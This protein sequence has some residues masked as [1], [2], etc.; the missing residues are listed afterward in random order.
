[1]ED[2][3]LYSQSELIEKTLSSA[4]LTNGVDERFIAGF[5]KKLNLRLPELLRGILLHSNG[6]EYNFGRMITPFIPSSIDELSTDE[7]W[8]KVFE[9]FEHQITDQTFERLK[10][11]ILPLGDDYSGE[12]LFFDLRKKNEYQIRI[13]S[14]DLNQEKGFAK[15]ESLGIFRDLL[16]SSLENEQKTSEDIYSLEKRNCPSEY[17]E[18][19]KRIKDVLGTS[20]ESVEPFCWKNE[21]T[22][23]GGLWFDVTLPTGSFNFQILIKKVAVEDFGYFRFTTKNDHHV[24]TIKNGTFLQESFKSVHLANDRCNDETLIGF[25]ESPLSFEV[26]KPEQV[27]PTVCIYETSLIDFVNVEHSQMQFC[28][29]A[30]SEGHIYRLNFKVAG[31]KIRE[32]INKTIVFLLSFGPKWWT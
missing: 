18:E 17:E 9:P 20:A 26:A 13:T 15:F 2:F 16:I 25:C 11:K 27:S 31:S 21:Q 32:Q 12:I 1:M 7:L 6:G 22:Y 19:I 4:I 29:L 23:G 3:G 24:I 30:L 14:G 5:E 8:K 28:V 10:G